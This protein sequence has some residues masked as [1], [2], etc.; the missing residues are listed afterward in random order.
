[1]I[2]VVSWETQSALY[3]IANVHYVIFRD[4]ALALQTA[5]LCKISK[6]QISKSPQTNE[7]RT[8]THKRIESQYTVL[9]LLNAF[10]YNKRTEK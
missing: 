4:C 6:S 7:R 5:K 2:A 10:T 8:Q 1:M 9:F 3:E